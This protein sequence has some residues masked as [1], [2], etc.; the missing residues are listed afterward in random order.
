MLSTV[1]HNFT[2]DDG[3]RNSTSDDGLFVTM[4][5]ETSGE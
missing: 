4:E 1:L 2:M 3:T 5:V